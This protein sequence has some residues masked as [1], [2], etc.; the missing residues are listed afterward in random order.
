MSGEYLRGYTKGLYVGKKKAMRIWQ[1]YDKGIKEAFDRWED[2]PEEK[3]K[4]HFAIIT[5]IND[6]EVCIEEREIE[7]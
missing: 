2:E 1:Q 6:T 4:I 7:V 3:R 5:E